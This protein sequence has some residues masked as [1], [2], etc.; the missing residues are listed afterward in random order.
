M[1]EQGFPLPG[2]SYKELVKIIQGYAQVTGQAVPA[3][4][5]SVIGI[6]ETIVSASNKFLVAVGIVQGGKK[7]TITSVGRELALA[8]EHDRQEEIGLHWRTIVG[9]TEFL[10]KVVAAVRIRR[11][12]AESDLDAHVAYSAGQPKSPRILAGSS[13]VVEILKIAGFLREEGGN[14]VAV[15]PEPAKSLEPSEEPPSPVRTIPL[16]MSPLRAESRATGS[17]QLNIDVRIQCT[18]KDLDDLGQKLRKVIED[19]NRR[20]D[21]RAAGTPDPETGERSV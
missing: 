1:P 2:S 6:N 16:M 15:T 7:K 12:M 5:A 17:V 21:K 4:V 18:P 13:A 14:L 3:D 9:A 19:F 10:Q 8:L 20:E 11:G